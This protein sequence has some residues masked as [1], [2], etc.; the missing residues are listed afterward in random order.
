MASP[1]PKNLGP[2]VF[3]DSRAS[4]VYSIWY[5]GSPGERVVVMP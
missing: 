2:T 3:P 5:T 4:R 1:V